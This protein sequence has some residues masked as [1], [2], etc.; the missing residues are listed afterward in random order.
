[1]ES[2]GHFRHC[3][4]CHERQPFGK[5]PQPEGSYAVKR[6]LCSLLCTVSFLLNWM[7]AQDYHLKVI[8]PKVTNLAGQ[9]FL[10]VKPY[11]IADC[12]KQVVILQTTLHRY[13]AENLGQWTWVLVHS[14]DWKPILERVHMDPNSPAF[15]ILERRQTFFE[16]VLLVPTP[17]R[18]MEL[19]SKW[20]IGFDQ[21]LDLA[22]THELGHALCNDPDERRADQFGQ[23]LRHGQTPKCDNQQRST[24]AGAR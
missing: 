3:A 12:E 21:L 4:A 17:R 7:E 15:S 19:I 20:Q 14:E 18:Q 13:R 2:F 1:M 10:C 22:V 5:K 16:D 23:R 11:A 24:A 6:S 8:R 9:Q